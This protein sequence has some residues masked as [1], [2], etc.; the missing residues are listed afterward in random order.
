MVT[1]MVFENIRSALRA[2]IRDE[3]GAVT[4]EWVVLSAAI[5][6]IGLVVLT[7]VAFQTDSASDKVAEYIAGVPSGY[8]SVND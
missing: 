2:V 4:V 3:Q 6:G 7:P 8:N 5:I 1:M